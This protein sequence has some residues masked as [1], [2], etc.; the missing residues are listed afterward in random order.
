[1]AW[2]ASSKR[3]ENLWIEYGSQR[4]TKVEE[5]GK[6]VFQRALVEV[7]EEEVQCFQ[8]QGRHAVSSEQKESCGKEVSCDG[9]QL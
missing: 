3:G 1:M 5:V 9:T 6:Q 2:T 7:L 4:Q 8:G